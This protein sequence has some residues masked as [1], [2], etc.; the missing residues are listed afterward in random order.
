MGRIVVNVGSFDLTSHNGNTAYS[1]VRYFDIPANAGIT[2]CVATFAQ[3]V[4]TGSFQ[5]KSFS[6]NGTQAHP[7]TPWPTSGI[8]LNPA[9]LTAGKNAFRA[10]VKS[11][12]GLSAR[13][14]IGDI[15]LTIDFID[16]GGGGTPPNIGTITLNKSSMLAGETVTV[17]LSP[18]DNGIYRSIRV[19]WQGE[20]ITSLIVGGDVPSGGDYSYTFPL[21]DCTRMPNDTNGSL[22]FE[23]ETS[24]DITITRTMI[25]QVPDSV[26][27]TIGTFTATR[28]AN[29][30]D[31][32]ITNY[33]Q[34]Y[35]KVS[36]AMGSVAG[37][38]G[39]SIQSY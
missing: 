30:V 12:A 36:L 15:Y 7:N 28:D 29:G 5:G 14:A 19:K 27:P 38:L 35:G 17:S 2:G 22:T 25:I 39:S 21:T 26:V 34:N 32:S 33:V 11:Q 10:S 23:M 24:V 3:H 8:S 6:L 16:V 1:S 20:L 13:W 4:N 9:L 37:A 31:A 18:C